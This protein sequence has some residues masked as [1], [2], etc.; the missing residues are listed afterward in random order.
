MAHAKVPVETVNKVLNFLASLP[1]SQVAELITEIQQ[2]S[3]IIEPTVEEETT[4][5]N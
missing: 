2:K 5:G 4:A 3:E 1:Y